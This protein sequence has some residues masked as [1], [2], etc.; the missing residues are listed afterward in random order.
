VGLSICKI[1]KRGRWRSCKADENG[2]GRVDCDRKFVE[3]VKTAGSNRDFVNV[4][5]IIIDGCV[6]NIMG[7][8]IKSIIRLLSIYFYLHSLLQ[9]FIIKGQFY[10]RKSKPNFQHWQLFFVYPNIWVSIA[11]FASS[12]DNK[13][14]SV[15]NFS[16]PMNKSWIFSWTSFC[17]LFLRIKNLM[18]EKNAA[19]SPMHCE[20]NRL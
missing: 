12:D 1:P 17:Q 6:L 4:V 9:V 15:W 19:I 8:K 11:I 16:S 3:N 10:K 5:F 20:Q 13:Y 18:V 14:T 2:S 7:M